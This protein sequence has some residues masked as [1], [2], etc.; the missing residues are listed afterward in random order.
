[1][2]APAKVPHSDRNAQISD[3]AMFHTRKF[4]IK[5]DH[6]AAAILSLRLRTSGAGLQVTDRIVQY[7]HHFPEGEYL[8]FL[9]LATNRIEEIRKPHPRGIMSP[10]CM[11]FCMRQGFGLTEHD[12]KRIYDLLEASPEKA[13]AT[14]R[15]ATAEVVYDNNYWQVTADVRDRL[16]IRI[17]SMVY[18]YAT[19]HAIKRA[20]SR[21]GLVLTYEAAKEMVTAMQSGDYIPQKSSSEDHRGTI[22]ATVHY[23][24]EDFTI[25]YDPATQ[26]IVTVTPPGDYDAARKRAGA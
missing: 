9:H 23:D 20:K 22:R 18:V 6:A 13:A 15:R 10:P 7:V 19:D 8:V 5:M 25:V 21:Y 17:N 26:M 11:T 4:G 2:T 3:L 12:Y 1:M 16:I 24:T 14:D